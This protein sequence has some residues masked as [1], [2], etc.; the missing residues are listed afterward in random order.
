M[1]NG[2]RVLNKLF[3]N[4]SPQALSVDIHENW[5]HKYESWPDSW[6][7]LVEWPIEALDLLKRPVAF[8]MSSFPHNIERELAWLRWSGC[9]AETAVRNSQLTIYRLLRSLA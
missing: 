3:A 9:T 5:S 4:V 6:R 7:D 2:L 1:K 8:T